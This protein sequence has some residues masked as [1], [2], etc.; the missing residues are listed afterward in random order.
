MIAAAAPPAERPAIE[1]RA[2][3]T[4]KSRMISRVMP[5]M[6]EGSP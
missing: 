5:A 1:T 2:A 4:L 6:S 3:S